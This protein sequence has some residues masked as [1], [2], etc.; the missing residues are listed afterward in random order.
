MKRI[1]AWNI[2]IKFDDGTVDKLVN[3]P[4]HVVRTVNAHLDD[5]EEQ[6]K[7]DELWH[8]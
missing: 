5:V 3:V 2:E 7:E 6:M 8:G 1:V 4:L